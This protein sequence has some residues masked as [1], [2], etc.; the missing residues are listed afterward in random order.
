M[1]VYFEWARKCF[2]AR[3]PLLSKK[4]KA[5]VK[6]YWM[7]YA[8]LRQIRSAGVA[9]AKNVFAMEVVSRVSFISGAFEGDLEAPAEMERRRGEREGVLGRRWESD[10]ARE[11]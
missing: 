4:D 9:T 1:S 5:S 7:A 11:C 3:K 6:P 10:A 2:V 8:K